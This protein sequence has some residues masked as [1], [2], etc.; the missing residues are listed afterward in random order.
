M[1]RWCVNN[2]KTLSHSLTNCLLERSNQLIDLCNARGSR[3]LI[4]LFHVEMWCFSLK[5]E[6]DQLTLDP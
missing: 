4:S 2:W 3:A 1:F 6:I 5:G